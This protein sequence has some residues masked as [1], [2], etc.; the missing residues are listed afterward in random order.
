MSRTW[1]VYFDAPGDV[2]QEIFTLHKG[3]NEAIA[4][5]GFKQCHPTLTAKRMEEW[6]K[7]SESES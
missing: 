2:K 7:Q 1:K 4:L 5:Q 6:T 3:S